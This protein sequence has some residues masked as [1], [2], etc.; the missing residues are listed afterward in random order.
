M[1]NKRY[2]SRYIQ[3][4]WV[5]VILMVILAVRL[6]VLAVGQEDRWESVASE[7]SIKSIYTSA[8]RGNIYDKYGRTIA[9]NKQIFTVTFN[10]SGLETEVINDS[11]YYLINKLIANG[12]KYTDNFPIK[13]IVATRARSK[14]ATPTN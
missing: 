7:Q 2:T 6:F 14:A 9:T 8:P 10:S 4:V 1:S 11:A 3:I 5:I 13:I 12:D